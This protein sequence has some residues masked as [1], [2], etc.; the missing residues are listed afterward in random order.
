MDWINFADGRN[1]VASGCLVQNL[2]DRKDGTPYTEMLFL[3]KGLLEGLE[4]FGIF[5]SS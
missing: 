5:T 4:C 2:L 3:C 1:G